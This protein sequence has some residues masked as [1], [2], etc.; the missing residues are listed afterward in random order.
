VN[1]GPIGSYT[2]V[3]LGALGDN[4]P[5]IG[6]P[7]SFVG[8]GGKS[9]PGCHAPAVSAGAAHTGNLACWEDIVDATGSYPAG[10]APQ[11]GSGGGGSYPAEQ[12]LPA[13]ALVFIR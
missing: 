6:A 9:F 11:V 4:D 5:G 7:D 3:R 1:G 12:A 2:N 10:V 13:F 8:I